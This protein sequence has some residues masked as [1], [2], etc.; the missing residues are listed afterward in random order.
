[1]ATWTGRGASSRLRGMVL[2]AL[3]TIFFS[4]YW[5]FGAGR[6]GGLAS[7]RLDADI[8]SSPHSSYDGNSGT[9]Q[10]PEK[11]KLPAGE[12]EPYDPARPP[13]MY[14]E[15]KEAELALPQHDEDLPSPEGKN[16]RF[17][18]FGN[19]MWGVGLNNQL[20]EI[21][22]NTEIA[23]RSGRAYVFTPFIWDPYVGD[24]YVEINANDHLAGGKTKQR[25]AR[26]PL[27]A[28]I[29]SPTSGAPWPDGD[30]PRVPRA[31]SDAWFDRMCP[32]EKRV[33][34]DASKVNPK[35]GVDF[36]KDEGIDIIE[37]WAKLL[38]E[39]ETPCAT[40]QW[41]TPR[42]ID[43][44]LMSS[45][46]ILSIWPSFSKSPVLT[47]FK[48]SPI[49]N[50]AVE[51]NLENLGLYPSTSRIEG[52]SSRLAGT[53]ATTPGLVTL[54][55]RRLDYERHCRWFAGWAEFEGWNKLHFLPDP[56][57]APSPMVFPLSN[58]S[59][60][61]DFDFDTNPRAQYL[62]SRCW[63][64]IDAIVQRMLHLKQEYADTMRL[65]K[66]YVSTNGREEWVEGLKTALIASG[67]TTVWTTR[68]LKLTWEESGVDSAI[69][70]ELATRGEL[71]VGNGFSTFTSTVVSLRLARGTDPKHI[72]F[73]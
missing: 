36:A 10:P 72:R 8:G 53:A 18:R 15:L 66:I 31:V 42:I 6:N 73:W 61:S 52:A 37:R 50:A 12:V 57:V 14:P 58:G 33:Q 22:L 23:R 38:R 71:F 64:E 69:D 17:V 56:Y 19:Q 16:A 63:L 27:R 43:F 25:A 1:M 68:D 40:I 49:V 48:W 46:R 55:V 9:S 30:S 44:D 39:M 60:P 5:L 47:S 21:L 34:L 54:H 35:I 45:D 7:P 11:V 41:E 24:A 2:A 62:L 67:W 20:F 29:D 59:M 13:P 51:R 65:D 32:Q 28:F 26:V 3:A 70:M 4:G